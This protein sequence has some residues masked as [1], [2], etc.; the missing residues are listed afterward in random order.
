MTYFKTHEA[1]HFSD[2][3][4]LLIGSIVPRPISI[5]STLNRDGSVNIAPFSF[6]TAVSAD[7]M[8]ITFCPMIRSS[9]GDYKDT[10][11]NIKWQQEFVVHVGQFKT[12]EA[13]N[14]CSSELPYGESEL[15]LAKLTTAPSSLIKTPRI[16]EFPI[17]FECILRDIIDYGKRPGSGCL[18]TGEVK[19][20]YVDDSIIKDGKII[21]EKLDPIGRGAGNDWYRCL[22]GRF[23][24]E[25]KM[26]A[27]IQK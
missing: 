4:K 12:A 15:E 7:P 26:Q 17:A 22:E 20:T 16:Q 23:E 18:I 21:S 24:L 9:T 3:Y 6:F 8:I 14:L 10:V 25:R 5:V 27:Q 19:A 2:N 13:I 1:S 11:I